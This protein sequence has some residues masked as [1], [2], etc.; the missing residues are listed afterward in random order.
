MSDP[1]TSE[2]PSNR[3]PPPE[4]PHHRTQQRAL[5]LTLGIAALATVFTVAALFLAP[6][7]APT[8][9]TPKPPLGQGMAADE[10]G[11]DV[12]EEDDAADADPEAAEDDDTEGDGTAQGL[13]PAGAR[14]DEPTR[15][16]GGPA[17]PQEVGLGDVEAFEVEGGEALYLAACA[18]CHMTDGRGAQ[19][20]ANYP[21]LRGNVRVQSREYVATYILQGGGGM[22][23]FANHLTDEQVAEIVNYIRQDLNNYQD[24]L[25]PASVRPL[26]Q[27][28]LTPDIDGSAG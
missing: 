13:S 14:E 8:S 12:P 16:L 20:A 25:S 17:A 27:P 4:P 10:D 22:P 28:T 19:G 21:A 7:P 2:S 3:P 6:E 15:L 5:T 26:R 1:R 23:S 9:V 11:E 24:G 18:S